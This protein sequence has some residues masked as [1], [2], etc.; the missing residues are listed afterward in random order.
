[1]VRLSDEQPTTSPRAAPTAGAQLDE[2]KGKVAVPEGSPLLELGMAYRLYRL[3]C[4]L[5]LVAGGE[6]TA[7]DDPLSW[8]ELRFKLVVD[9]VS[10]EGEGEGFVLTLPSNSTGAATVT[11]SGPKVGSL[12]ASKCS[13]M[14]WIVIVLL[15]MTA[16]QV[17]RD[18]LNQKTMHGSGTP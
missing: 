5:S 15:E 16:L 8:I 1:M 9:G 13:K 12:S 18:L 6:Q 7:L 11:G 3:T 4:D 10:M 2:L 17:S 14:L